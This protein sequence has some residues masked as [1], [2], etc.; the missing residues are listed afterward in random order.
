MFY[1]KADIAVLNEEDI[2]V[3]D[4]PEPRKPDEI[5]TTVL[6]KYQNAIRPPGNKFKKIQILIH[7]RYIR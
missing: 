1:L 4:K 2:P 7:I 6:M 3:P 5:R